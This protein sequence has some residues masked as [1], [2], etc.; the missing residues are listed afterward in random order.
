MSRSQ[1]EAHGRP[2]SGKDVREVPRAAE[3]QC[4]SEEQL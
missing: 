2:G 3:G 1:G 4:W